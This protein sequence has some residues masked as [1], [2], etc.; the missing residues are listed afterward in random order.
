MVDEGRRHMETQPRLLVWL[1]LVIAGSIIAFNLLG[2]GLRDRLDP[3]LGH[4]AWP[5][6]EAAS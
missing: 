6:Q 3:K 1:S 5:R 4:S 2:D